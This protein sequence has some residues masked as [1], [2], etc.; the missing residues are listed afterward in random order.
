MPTCYVEG[1]STELRDVPERRWSHTWFCSEGC[2]DGTFEELPRPAS[3]EMDLGGIDGD[4]PG[5]GYRST[6]HPYYLTGVTR[7]LRKARQLEQDLP[8]QVRPPTPIDPS[9]NVPDYFRDDPK[10]VIAD[11]YFSVTSAIDASLKYADGELNRVLHDLVESEGVAEQFDDDQLSTL[12][13]NL[14]SYQR[15][16]NHELQGTE[17][18]EREPPSVKADKLLEFLEVE[19][20]DRNGR[21]WEGFKLT[22]KFRDSLEHSQVSSWKHRPTTDAE[23]KGKMVE[24]LERR[25]PVE[26]PILRSELGA[27]GIVIHDHMPSVQRF[28][29]SEYGE[30]VMD[31]C[32]LF[33]LEFF[34]KCGLSRSPSS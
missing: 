10:G 6:V 16:P 1:C 14:E 7:A 19:P 20:M 27:G 17:A 28:V 8:E 24:E 23:S 32:L 5:T 18:L 21:I 34:S 25:R 2:R 22:K 13:G 33:L 15:H 26:N 29:S 12:R 3:F 11:Y 9:T 31:T 4:D 30:W